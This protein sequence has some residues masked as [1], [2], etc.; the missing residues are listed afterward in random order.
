MFTFCPV[1]GSVD[2]DHL[3]QMTLGY[4]EKVIAVSL[5]HI[6]MATVHFIGCGKFGLATFFY[7]LNTALSFAPP[8]LLTLFLEG[9]EGTHPRTQLELGLISLGMLVLP[10]LSSVT[11]LAS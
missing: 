9:L 5:S 8:I 2:L 7:L 11:S 4:Q 3:H 1:Q 10:M 6:T